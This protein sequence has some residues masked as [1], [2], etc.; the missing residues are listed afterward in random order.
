MDF[1]ASK[2]FSLL[3]AGING[4]FAIGAL[5]QQNWLLLGLS[6]V[7]FVICLNNYR[8]APN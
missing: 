2:N 3:C 4:F 7:F 6:S 1:I 8:E 5:T